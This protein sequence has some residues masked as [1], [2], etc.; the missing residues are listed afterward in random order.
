M[1]GSAYEVPIAA[2]IELLTTSPHPMTAGDIA[3]HVGVPH[4]N[5]SHL[6]ATIKY[7]QTPGF[8]RLHTGKAKRF[9][10]IGDDKRLPSIE[11]KIVVK[12]PADLYR[13]WYNPATGLTG[14]QLG[15]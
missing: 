3:R 12:E 1:T 15:V 13:G 11:P 7:R 2:I 8:R 5:M 14:S 4:K 10:T 9:Y 6:L